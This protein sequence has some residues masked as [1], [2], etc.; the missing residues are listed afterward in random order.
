MRYLW[1]ILFL[2]AI[3]ALAFG[4]SLLRR[5]A[6]YD[7]ELTIVSPH[8]EGIRVEFGRA[9][10][11]HY[12]KTS[13]TRVRVVWLD[14]GTTSECVKYMRERFELAEAR[15]ERGIGVDIFF[16]GGMA[17][18]P[19][20]AK[21]NYFEPS[22][23]PPELAAK[24]PATLGGQTLRDPQNRFHA[25]CLSGFG[26]VY[27]ERVLNAA[28]LPAPATWD[29][30][31]R[32]ELHG[33]ISC[34]DPSMSGS[35]HQ[36]F[37][38]VL[39]AEGWEKGFATLG[40]MLSNAR[41]FNEG[42][43]SVPRDVS[44]GQAAAGPCIDFYATAPI[45]RQGAT[46]LKLVIPNGASVV[47][48]DGIALVRGAPNKAAAQAFIA[49]VL[50]EAGQCLWYQTRGSAGGPRDYDLERL[51]VMPSIYASGAPTH[52]VLNPFSTSGD[53][54]YDAAKASARWR[55]LDGLMRSVWVDAHEELWEAR[56]AIIAAGRDGDLGNE[57][58]APP[59]S[60][61]EFLE[62]AKKK[63]SSD[64]LNDLRIKWTGW[65]RRRY[66]KVRS[67]N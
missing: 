59:M 45:R 49:F 66:A 44:L 38:I 55:L 27:N 12:L 9:F 65:A 13:G 8:W 40:R 63:F 51:P 37:E 57:L 62:L 1:T 25:A 10:S 28:K 18:L 5:E 48:P 4:P 67:E 3:L 19:N 33:W 24:L 35:L 32:P 47:T 60:E 39:Q 50:G 54:V 43:P 41:A 15:G 34:G 6:A 53:F 7:E 26:F 21:M 30:L 22:P 52:T 14:E 2:G 42:G 23:L 61:A 58:C 31:G 20:M 36:A 11:E 29:D 17:E 46:H 16:G 56:S 64:E